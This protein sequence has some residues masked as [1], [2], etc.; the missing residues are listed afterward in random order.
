MDRKATLTA[1]ALAFA[2]SPAAANGGDEG[3][4]EVRA[5]VVETVRIDGAAGETLSF[6]PSVDGPASV[7]AC[8]ISEGGGWA[9]LADSANGDGEYVAVAP[10]GTR[11]TYSVAVSYPTKSGIERDLPEG[12]TE[13]FAADPADAG[14]EDGGNLTIAADFA[15]ETA[16]ASDLLTLILS[17]L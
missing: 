15:E 8:V 3:T 2:A 14:C 1:L 11:S 10:D 9:A 12:E 16:S 7:E 6:E 5:R 17:P 4:A 13:T